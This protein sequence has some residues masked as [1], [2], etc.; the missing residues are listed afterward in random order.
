M[1]KANPDL[2][3]APTLAAHD[4]HGAACPACGLPG[5]ASDRR[6]TE[7]TLRT[8]ALGVSAATGEALFRAIVRY[9]SLA[10]GVDFAFVGELEP[11]PVPRLH[12]LAMANRGGVIVDN[13]AYDLHGTP[14]EDVVG[15]GFQYVPE[16]VCDLYPGENMLAAYGL[17]SYAGY[18]LID[19]AGRSV[20]VVS[21]VHAEPLRDRELVESTLQIFAVR[22]AAELERL[23]VDKALRASEASYRAIFES[24]EDAIFVHD[25]DTAAIVDVNPRACAAYGYTCEELRAL[26]VGEFSA[27]EPPYALEGALRYIE[28]AKAGKPQRFEWHR[29]NKDGSLHWDEV[30]LKRA[31]IGGVDRIIALTREIT[32]RRT[33]EEERVRLE[34]QLRQAQK[35]EA[36]GQLTGGIAHDFNNIL[37]GVMG[38]IALARERVEHLGDPKLLQYLDRAERSGHRARDLIQQMLTFSRG[39]RGEPRPLSL[40]ALVSETVKLLGSTFPATLE[41]RTELEPATPPVLLDPVQAGQVLMNLCINARD[42]MAGNGPLTVSVRSVTQRHAVCA[43]CRQVVAGDFVELAVH[44][45]GAGIAEGALERIFEPFFSTKEKGKGSG[46]GLAVVHGIV[47]EHGGHILVDTTRG[48]GTAFRVQFPALAGAEAAP[49][50]AVTPPARVT[51]RLGGRVLLIDDD[52]AAGAFMEDLL[53]GWGLSVVRARD[54]AEGRERFLADPGGY[55]LAVLD[56]SMP[57]V[58]GTELAAELVHRRPGFPVILNTANADAFTADELRRHGVRA[59]VRKPVDTRELFDLLSAILAGGPG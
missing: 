4:G 10:L 50:A 33:A 44:D 8:V 3:A 21:V 27:G 26:D 18:P 36:I 9:L 52:E 30:Y 49:Q 43:S 1:S 23:R 19:S 11:G 45:A 57:R 6:R 41:I 51:A 22:A 14:C 25:I 31:T 24:S 17:Q 37:T 54:G 32:E 39:G 58:T 34:A 53:E 12:T 38:Y 56:Q 35:M 29:R 2:V 47:H 5:A 48:A 16:G 20:G 13:L 46:M 59:L 42:A 7:E 15:V 40:T 55:D 28:R